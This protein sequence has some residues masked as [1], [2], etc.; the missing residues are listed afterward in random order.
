MN[1]T[2]LLQAAQTEFAD[3][4]AALTFEGAVVTGR[5][6][7]VSID[8][9]RAKVLFRKHPS[10]KPFCYLALPT[11]GGP[12]YADALTR[13]LMHPKLKGVL[14]IGTMEDLTATLWAYTNIRICDHPVD[15][16]SVGLS[17]EAAILLESLRSLN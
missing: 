11:R 4:I 15:L 8:L 7:L 17:P 1:S 12:G 9:V 5:H 16:R 3:E 13:I 2:L 6:R 10:K 14:S